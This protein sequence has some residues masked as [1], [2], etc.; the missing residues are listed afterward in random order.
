MWKL[1]GSNVANTGQQSACKILINSIQANTGKN[2]P[3]LEEA[4]ELPIRYP[5]S[6]KY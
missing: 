5:S 1:D 4:D 2:K 6:V 3:A